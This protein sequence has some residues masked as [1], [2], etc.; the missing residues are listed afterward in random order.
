MKYLYIILILFAFSTA[1][2]EE[3]EEEC[4]ITYPICLEQPP[5]NELCAAAF[6]RWFF[7]SNTQTCSEIAYSG[8]SAYGFDNQAD[9]EACA[10]D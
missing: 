1:C 7:D 4:E 5:T 3:E 8:C 9:C 2:S 6:S 10:C